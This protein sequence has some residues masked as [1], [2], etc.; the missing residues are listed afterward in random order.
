MLSKSRHPIRIDGYGRCRDI[1][2]A[3]YDRTVTGAVAVSLAASG[4]DYVRRTTP[5]ELRC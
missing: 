4:G 3:E 2:P 1:S 5:M